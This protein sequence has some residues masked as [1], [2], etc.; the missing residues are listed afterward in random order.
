MVDKEKGFIESMLS[1]FFKGPNKETE[2]GSDKP[3]SAH[4]GPE[5]PH[6]APR[7]PNPE[8]S[9]YDE[10]EPGNQGAEGSDHGPDEDSDHGPGV[11]H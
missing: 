4:G 6:G 11:S 1:N 8:G 5:K 9:D 3:H 7:V 10:P 2:Q